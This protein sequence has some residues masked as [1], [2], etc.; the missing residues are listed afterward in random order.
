MKE[1]IYGIDCDVTQEQFPDGK[2]SV[3]R[4]TV[5]DW[6]DCSFTL[7]LRTKIPL[8]LFWGRVSWVGFLL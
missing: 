2:H 8:A 7:D 3:Y 4:F 5:P 1:R 6:P